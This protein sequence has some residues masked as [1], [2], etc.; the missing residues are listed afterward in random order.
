MNTMTKANIKRLDN[1]WE[2][3]LRRALNKR[4]YSLHKSRI[5]SDYYIGVLY[6]I[7]DRKTGEESEHGFTSLLKVQTWFDS[8]FN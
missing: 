1:N 2:R 3:R 7:R 5:A 4:G 8:V 6:T